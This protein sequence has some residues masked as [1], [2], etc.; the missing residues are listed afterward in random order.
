[1]LEGVNLTSSIYT[2]LSYDS[3][4]KIFNTTSGS[5]H[6]LSLEY[7]GLG[8]DIGFTKLVAET[9]WYMPLVWKFTGFAHGKAGWVTE[10]SGKILPDYEKFYLGGI[11]SLRGFDFQD[12]SLVDENGA[13]IGGDKMVQ[14]NFELIFP[15]IEKQG[16]VGVVFYDT[17]NVYSQ[18]DDIDIGN[19]RKSAGYGIRWYSPMG[20]MRL[21]YGYIL[22]P[23]PG[24]DADGKWE[25]SM[26]GAF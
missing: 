10:N 17:G 11:N 16:L 8:G 25:F 26:G 5:E 3:R 2:A 24:E 12:I 15:L 6:W 1:V 18:D 19:L 22:D 23:Q 20:P 14:F 13:K 4:D 7:A 9:G 21:E